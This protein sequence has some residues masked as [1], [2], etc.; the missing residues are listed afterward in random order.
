MRTYGTDQQKRPERFSMRSISIRKEATPKG[1]RYVATVEGAEGE[2]ELTFTD[3]GPMLMSADHTGAPDG[4][5]GTGVAAALVEHMIADAQPWL[6]DH[7]DLPLREGAL[8]TPAHTCDA[9]AARVL[10]QEQPVCII[11][12]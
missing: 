3:R 4:M 10:A 9:S 11:K 7:S 2:A 5:R 1:G 8:D 6:Q 12:E